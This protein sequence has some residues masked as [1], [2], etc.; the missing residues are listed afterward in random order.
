MQC[1]EHQELVGVT[2]FFL[3]ALLLAA[4]RLLMPILSTVIALDGAPIIIFTVGV[5]F[6]L[7]VAS[8]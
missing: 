8:F 1:C 2:L 7:R 5:I 6:G 3:I 4:F